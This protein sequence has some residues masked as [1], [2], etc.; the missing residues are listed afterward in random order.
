MHIYNIYH[1]KHILHTEE[2]DKWTCELHPS[3][4]RCYAGMPEFLRTDLPS[5]PKSMN[6]RREEIE[7]EASGDGLRERG[8]RG[9]VEGSVVECYEDGANVLA[10]CIVY[11]L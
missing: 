11:I 7:H 4:H 6:Q 8:T 1:I 2:Y 3:C 9:M 10:N 5:A